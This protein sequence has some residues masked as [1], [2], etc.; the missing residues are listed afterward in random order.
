MKARKMDS[1]EEY[2]LFYKTVKGDIEEHMD[3]LK[4]YAS[5][6]NSIVELGVRNLVSTWA[7]LA[8]RPKKLI[9]V[10]ITH[11]ITNGAKK[12]FDDAFRLARE[13]KIDFAFIQADDLE[14]ELEKTDLLFIDTLHTREQLT[15]E[16]K[17]HA[18]KARKYIILHDTEIPEMAETAFEFLKENKKWRLLEQ[19][20]NNN[21]LIVLGKL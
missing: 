5:K 1:I 11:P 2:F 20:H 16:L 9:S 18:D 13:N 6:S 17:L 4:K 3:T 21:G 12:A 15:Q 10:D 19:R 7:F 14:I 8:A